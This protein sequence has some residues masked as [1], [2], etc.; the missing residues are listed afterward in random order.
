MIVV[1][2]TSVLINLC[3]V[4]QGRLFEQLFEE[5]VIPPEVAWEFARLTCRTGRFAG[6]TIPKGIGQQAPTSHP[7]AVRP[8]SLAGHRLHC[9]IL[10]TSH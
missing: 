6:L 8:A 10:N 5:V 3:S 2:D 7:A 9:Q 1:A 4:G